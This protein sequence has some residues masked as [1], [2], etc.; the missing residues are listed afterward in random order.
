MNSTS[1]FGDTGIAAASRPQ[2]RISARSALRASGTLW[3]LVAVLG[4]L[5][6]A[7]YVVGFYGLSAA[8]G[9]LEDW[10]KVLPQGVV[11]G[12]RFLNTVLSLHLLFVVVIIVGGALQL[13]P[14]LRRTR[15][16]F[17][18][19][20]GRLYLLAAGILSVGGLILVWGRGTVGDLSQHLAISL[21][22][23]LILVFSAIAWQ[24]ARV[25]CVE[26]HRRWALRLFLAVS[27]VWFFRIGLMLWIVVNQGPAG[28]DPK[29]FTGPFLTFLSFAQYLLPLAVLELYFRTL[30]RGHAPAQALMAGAMLVMSLATVGGIGAATAIM[31]LPRF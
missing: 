29:S 25:R 12:Q 30:E 10:A 3:L 28:F 27:G 23:L 18:R 24:Q 14:W 15:P 1:S 17:H 22:A 9:R 2:R 26:A 4:Q 16:G 21:N 6:L 8:Q 20:S 7:I 11:P 19:W 5:L 13:L 31:W